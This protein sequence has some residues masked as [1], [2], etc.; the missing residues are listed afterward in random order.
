MAN[1]NVTKNQF[2]E[3]SHWHGLEMSANICKIKDL[4]FQPSKSA[5]LILTF[6]LTLAF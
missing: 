4:W 5:I 6:I 1:L 2:I 3:N